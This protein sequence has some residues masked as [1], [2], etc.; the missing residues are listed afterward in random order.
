[1]AK[2]PTKQQMIDKIYEEIWWFS[3]ERAL[4]YYNAIQL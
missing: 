2:K 3:Y 1:M 4:S